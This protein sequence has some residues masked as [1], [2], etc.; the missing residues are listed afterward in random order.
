MQRYFPAFSICMI[1]SLAAGDKAPAAGACFS[2]PEI[3]RVCRLNRLQ[4]LH[5]AKCILNFT[6]SASFSLPS[7]S[8]EHR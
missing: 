2:L 7:S 3:K 6:R 8:I 1:F 4:S 5:M